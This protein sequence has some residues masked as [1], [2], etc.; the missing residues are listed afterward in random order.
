[1]IGA[2]DNHLPATDEDIDARGRRQP[3][4]VQIVAQRQILRGANRIE[5]AKAI[6]FLGGIV[7]ARDETFPAHNRAYPTAAMDDQMA[8]IKGMIAREM[9]RTPKMMLATLPNCS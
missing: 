4:N 7:P 9:P 1:M 6:P 3:A 8:I 2:V 5:S